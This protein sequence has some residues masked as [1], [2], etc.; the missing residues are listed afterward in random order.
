MA[1]RSVV[2][3]SVRITGDA[4][5]MVNEFNRADNSARRSAARIDAEVDRL[6]RNVKRKFSAGD[7]GKDV[8]RGL[9]IGSGF[10]VAQQAAEVI[11]NYWRESAESA[12]S[13]EA[14][15]QRA[16]NAT[17]AMIKA[18]QSPEQQ[19]T[20]LRKQYAAAEAELAA[21]RV[22]GQYSGFLDAVK[23]GLNGGFTPEQQAR[24]AELV[25]NVQE[26]GLAVQ[27]AQDSLVDA[28][29]KQFFDGV[30]AAAKEAEEAASGTLKTAI[31]IASATGPDFAA[32][33]EV[34]GNEGADALAAL[35]AELETQAEHFRNMGDPMRQYMQDLEQVR[36]LLRLGD[37]TRDEA[38]AA[39]KAIQKTMEAAREKLNRHQDEFEKEWVQM[40]TDVSDRA[41]QA[42]ADMVLTG[43]ASMGQLADI[44]ARTMLEIVARMAIINP[45][46]NAVF[47][48]FGGWKAL[49]TFWAGG[50]KALGGAV[51]AGGMYPINETGE[52]EVLTTGGRDYLMM[53]ARSGS[54]VPVGRGAA[55]VGGGDTYNIDARGADQAAIRHLESVILA[56]NGSIEPR[57]LAAV[58]NAGARGKV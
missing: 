30:A 4:S 6:A 35:N 40:W 13:I 15:T 38:E 58:R 55:S 14:S 31:A 2:E 33:K 48:G 32:L 25:A 11:S 39:E 37:L 24:I 20:T 54:V 7:I 52:P 23:G 53:G 22:P 12:K 51:A 47:G 19:L 49:P 17:L 3:T 10:A 9:G 44:V 21:A 57:A 36:E 46:M 56:L 27:T 8:L 28:E 41:G 43:E 1:K 29:L 16:L 5:G 18:R 34:T 45:L 42:F 50:G 26:L